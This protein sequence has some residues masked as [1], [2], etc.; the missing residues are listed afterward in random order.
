MHNILRL[1]G[2][3]AIQLS[4]DWMRS[5]ADKMPNS[6]MLSA[7]CESNE[8][9]LQVFDE[10]QRGLEQCKWP[11]R[12]HRL[13]HFNL[14]LFIDGAHTIESLALCLKWFQNEIHKCRRCSNYVIFNVTGDRNAL[15]MMQM[16]RGTIDLDRVL[17][18]PNL[19]R[20]SQENE[21]IG[22]KK[23]ASLSM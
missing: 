18:V 8:M 9:C 11:G 3:L 10:V 12:F 7:L 23:F 5:N 21:N 16:I 22:M 17:F 4:Y 14:Q 15:K 1:N 13:D 19:A 20:R 6:A 2:S